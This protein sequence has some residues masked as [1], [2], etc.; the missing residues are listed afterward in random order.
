MLSAEGHVVG[1][2][3]LWANVLALYV[4]TDGIRR[5]RGVG[6]ARPHLSLRSRCNAAVQ[7]RHGHCTLLPREGGYNRARL[8]ASP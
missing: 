7:C 2:R 3:L 6:H 4:D 8:R 1:E 5:L